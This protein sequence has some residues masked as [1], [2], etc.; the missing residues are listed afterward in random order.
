MDVNRLDGMDARR[1]PQNMDVLLADKKPRVP[2]G[3]GLVPLAW[4][5][6]YAPEVANLTRVGWH[7]PAENIRSKPQP[8]RTRTH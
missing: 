2:R 6:K 1:P 4:A 5:G 7:N 3:P 8:L